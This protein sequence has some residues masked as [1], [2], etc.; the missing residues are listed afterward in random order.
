MTSL[1]LLVVGIVKKSLDIIAH[2]LDR[3]EV[4][5][6]QLSTE[7][8][9]IYLWSSR[10]QTIYP[11]DGKI[12]FQ[13]Q[14]DR[15]EEYLLSIVCTS[16]GWRVTI[17]GL[18]FYEFLPLTTNPSTLEIRGKSEIYFAGWI[19]ESKSDQVIIY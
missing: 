12:E 14:I 3:N 4:F 8:R 7:N 13:T 2:D 6:A 16:E 17:N 1:Q 9:T 10:N 19:G 11:E 5:H 18:Q 15:E